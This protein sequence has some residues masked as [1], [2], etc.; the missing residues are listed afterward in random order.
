MSINCHKSALFNFLSVTFLFI[1]FNN[2]IFAQVQDSVKY[3][4]TNVSF[5][6]NSEM[7][8]AVLQTIVSAK[9]SPGWLSKMLKK[10]TSFGENP[11][12]FD[13]LIISS[14]AAALKN[15]YFANGFFKSKII[16]KYQ[17][18]S[19]NNTASIL[20]NIIEGTPAYLNSFTVNGLEYLPPEFLNRIDDMI[21]I[22]TTTRFSGKIIDEKQINILTFCRDNGYMLCSALGSPSVTID[23]MINKVFVNIDFYLGNRYVVNDVRVE[24]TGSG[25]DLV[26][27]ELVKEVAGI[28]VNSMYSFYELQ[29][30]QVRLYRTNLFSSA[31]IAGVS[32]D[33][34]G[35]YVPIKIITDIG[36]VHEL[37]PEIIVN[38]E[39]NALNLGFGLGYV[40]KNFLGN[41]RKLTL[42]A[43]TAAQSITDFLT[44][45]SL[46]DTSIYG[47]GDVRAILEQPFVF[48]QPINTK[49]ETYIT[50]Q[51]RK[52]EYNASI[53]G[54]K[55]SLNFEL[56]RKVYLTSFIAYFNWEFSRYVYRNQYLINAY[57]TLLLR[58]PTIPSD[59]AAII[60]ARRVGQQNDKSIKSTNAL[61][62][63]DI[64]VNKTD[65][66][67]FPTEGYNLS[68]LAEDGNSIPFLLSKL[69][70]YEYSA[71]GYLKTVFTSSAYFSLFSSKVNIIGVKLKS[72]YIFAHRGD[73]SLIPLNQRFYSGGS[74]SL[75]G[76]Q[77]RELVPPEYTFD[78]DKTNSEDFEAVLLRGVTP[79]GF[80]QLEG[81]V[82][83]RL[84]L[85]DKI[86]TA[87]FADFGNTW[88]DYKQ[89][90]Y[91]DVAIAI[92][93]GIRYYSDFAPIR[94]DFG[95]KFYDPS[96]RK[97]F[98]TKSIMSQ[99]FQLH[100]GIG[101][102][103]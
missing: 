59:S 92:G 84:R 73:I 38:N 53:Y 41:A 83:A 27:D 2:S 51:K 47:Y 10:F 89:F 61:L 78:L 29:K 100:L 77:A 74:N 81:S 65:D 11:V 86:G 24:K 76:W 13:S 35:N 44:H 102:A 46:N 80:F 1:L 99:T 17:I 88:N 55:L 3:E 14:D 79:G 42:S 68:L 45:P 93:F 64:G 57:T 96:D 25:K 39:D 33:T 69:F 8:T 50:V 91:D 87:V 54:T 5:T 40:K 98:F 30:G 82:E 66:F 90:Q 101:E 94:V 12:Y 72:G 52:A 31:L 85:L 4:L 16:T 21:A 71:T 95:F 9:E 49:L 70:N 97:S 37:S 32:T 103:F 7:P 19:A 48:G 20:Y 15:Y 26:D 60:A 43:S 18:D 58:D 23:T 22:D 56:P 6:G 36:L 63:F 62:G 75:R 28:K 67:F 34:S